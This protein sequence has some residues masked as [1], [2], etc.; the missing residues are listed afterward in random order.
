[1][2]KIFTLLLG[3]LVTLV[4][5]ADNRPSVTI[6]SSSKKYEVVIDGKSYYNG[7]MMNIANLGNGKH[8]VRVFEINRSVFRTTRKLV[9]TSSFRLRN[10][11]VSILVDP[12]GNLRII[13]SKD[14]RDF[15][16]DNGPRGRDNDYGRR[17]RD[18]R[19]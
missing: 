5:F 17:D 15:G 7:N 11:D 16:R 14:G 8:T 12:R 19:F 3:T 2:K 1:M 13:E 4:V 6:R 10:Q 9:S 18:G